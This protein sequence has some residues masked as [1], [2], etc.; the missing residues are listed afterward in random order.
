MKHLSFEEI[1]KYVEANKP[2]EDTF[3]LVARVN[4]HIRECAECNEKVEAFEK[5]YSMLREALLQNEDGFID[6]MLIQDH[7]KNNMYQKD[8]LKMELT[9]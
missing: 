5:V 9:K 7:M 4:N 1:T 2:S 3:K 6:S 8:G